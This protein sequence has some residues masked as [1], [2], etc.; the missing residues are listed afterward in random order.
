MPNKILEI[1]EEELI[2]SQFPEKCPMCGDCLSEDG[3]GHSDGYWC[4]K[5]HW[6]RDYSCTW[7]SEQLLGKYSI[8][9]Y[10]RQDD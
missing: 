7:I 6:H 2:N 10:K 9:I 8:M 3:D 5:C 1:L 4:D